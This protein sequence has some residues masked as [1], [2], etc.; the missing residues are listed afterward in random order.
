[1]IGAIADTGYT[2]QTAAAFPV[3]SGVSVYDYLLTFGGKGA[4]SS[5]EKVAAGFSGTR[6][7]GAF[8]KRGERKE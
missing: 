3:N 8:D 4:R 1:M 2:L 5:V 7:A 6:L